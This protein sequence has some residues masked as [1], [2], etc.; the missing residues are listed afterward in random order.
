MGI[1]SNSNLADDHIWRTFESSEGIVTQFGV[2]AD[3][4]RSRVRAP[5]D[6]MGMGHHG[7]YQASHASE[8]WPI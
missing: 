5:A 4:A 3:R 6:L 1:L 8:S 7:G 2:L